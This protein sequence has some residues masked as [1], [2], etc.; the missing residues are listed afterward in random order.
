M[1]H[2][3]ITTYSMSGGEGEMP[4]EEIGL[5]CGYM[6]FIYKQASHGVSA[7][8]ASDKGVIGAEVNRITSQIDGSMAKWAKPS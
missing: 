5:S 2:I 7:D 3:I 1:Q 4:Q 8:A 6:K